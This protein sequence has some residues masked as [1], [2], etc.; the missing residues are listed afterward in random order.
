M[1]RYTAHELQLLREYLEAL[2]AP[3]AEN[4]EADPGYVQYLPFEG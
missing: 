2:V 1:W 3:V 4:G